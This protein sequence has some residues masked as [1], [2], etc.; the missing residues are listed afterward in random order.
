MLHN[1][2]RLFFHFV[3]HAESTVNLQPELIGGR[4]S[5]GNLTVRGIA[6]AKAL[7]QRLVEEGIQFDRFY[8][9]PLPRAVE[10]AEH[11]CAEM[12]R[13]VE[14]VLPCDE[15]VGFSQ[16]EWER[17]PRAQVYTQENLAYIN[18]KGYLFVPPGGESQR[19]VERRA[20]SWLEDTVLYS[21]E[22]L[23][24]RMPLHIGVVAHG[25][26]IK[27]LFH[28]IMGFNDRLIWRIS[29]DNCSLSR[30]LFSKEGWFLLCINDGFHLQQIGRLSDKYTNL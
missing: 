24:M 27:C 3:R 7:G 30:F 1:T 16:G 9:S 20:A 13:A 8:T 14:S 23:S 18:T 10:T 26:V 29:L 6:Q 25:T 21:P 15:L 11:I 5:A 2:V 19:M 17:K 12:G 4:S 22:I 28:H